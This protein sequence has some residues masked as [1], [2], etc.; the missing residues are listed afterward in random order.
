[1]A[2][3]VYKSPGVFTRE[4]DT[5]QPATV[6]IVGTP[7]GIIGTAE[8]GPAFV[9][10]TVGN[11]STFSQQFGEITGESFG[12]IAAQEYLRRGGN[13]VTYLRVLGV[14]DGKQRN[15]NG[16]VTNAGFVV[17]NRKV[18]DT[19]DI[20]DNQYANAGIGA[21]LGRTYFL[22]CFMSESAGSTVFSSAGIQANNKVAEAKII[23]KDFTTG[24]MILEPS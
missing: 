12:K 18:Q 16:S 6:G 19:G 22:G 4:V 5:S 9:P 13:A 7:A 15:S 11:L 1:M 17:G 10:I 14:G 23:I 24:S 8:L 20:G 2:E 3:I 21:V